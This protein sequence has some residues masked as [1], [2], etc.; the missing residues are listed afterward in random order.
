MIKYTLLIFLFLSSC[1]AD[2]NSFSFVNMDTNLSVIYTGKKN[3]EMEKGITNFVSAFVKE[4]SY[5]DKGSF[6]Y[7]LNEFAFKQ[8]VSIPNR[9][10]LLIEQSM[11][12]SENSNGRFDITY[13]SAGSLWEQPGDSVPKDSALLKQR[14]T[15]KDVVFD[16]KKNEIYYKKEHVK[17]DL[18]GIAKGASI[19]Y[20]GNILN[21]Y[22]YD[23]FI[24]NYGG[25]LLVCGNKNGKNWVVG[26]KDPRDS[27]VMLKKIKAPLNK[28]VGVATSGNYERYFSKGGRKY[29]HI[30][31]PKNGKPVDDAHSV[32]VISKD[33][34]TSDALAT[35]ISV[36]SKDELFLKKI[37]DKF[38]L[39]VYTLT[40]KNLKWSEYHE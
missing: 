14:T 11:F 28:C 16:C 36:G 27:R 3:I 2:V 6:V 23:N 10:C 22:G 38:H 31:D 34:T 7:K 26:I 8:K 40:G 9:L 39:K 24:I 29:S 5:Y 20:T 19:D 21:R 30:I 18:G 35:A 4:L 17:I 37:V 12:Y 32:T 25:D 13:K 15:I 33:A 1:K